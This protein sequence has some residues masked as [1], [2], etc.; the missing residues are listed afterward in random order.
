[1]RKVIA[2]FC[3]SLATHHSL[4]RAA[5]AMPPAAAR[6]DPTRLMHDHYGDVRK[7]RTDKSGAKGPGATSRSST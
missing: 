1:M 7:A 4:T 6:P 5:Q 3:V 2:D